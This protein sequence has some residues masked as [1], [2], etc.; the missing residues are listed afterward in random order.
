IMLEIVLTAMLYVLLRPVDAALSMAAAMARFAMVAVMAVILML[1]AG[2][3]AMA[4]GALPGSPETV[5][6]LLEIHAQGIFVWGVL[7]SLHLWILGG[8][9]CR[10]GFLPKWFGAGMVIGS[11]GY[12]INGFAALAQA[13]MPGL[14]TAS[15]I[16]LAVATVAE[17]GFALWLVIRG[18]DET[19]WRALAA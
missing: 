11:F 5:L 17:L 7:F 1:N 18:L 12:L 15:A 9:I 3:F 19:K 8:L 2:A 6:A 14:S 4:R 10:S 16:L 13:E